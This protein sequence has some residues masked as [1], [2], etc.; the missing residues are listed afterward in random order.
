MFPEVRKRGEDNSVDWSHAFVQQRNPLN[1]WASYFLA[2]RHT[3]RL[4]IYKIKKEEIVE[5]GG[6]DHHAGMERET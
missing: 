3:P 5:V 4:F 6:D 2:I 1:N